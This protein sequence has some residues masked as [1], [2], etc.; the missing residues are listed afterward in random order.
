[1]SEV[2]LKV[3]KKIFPKHPILKVKVGIITLKKVFR[4]TAKMGIFLFWN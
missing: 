4:L 3:W 1:M 2:S